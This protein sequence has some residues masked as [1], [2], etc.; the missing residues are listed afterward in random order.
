MHKK[1]AKIHKI[2]VDLDG[3][4]CN[5]DSS[6]LKSYRQIYPDYRF[7]PLD[8]RVGQCSD[9]DYLQ[10]FSR[11]E[12]NAVQRIL[13]T[14]GFFRTLEPNADAVEAVKRLNVRRRDLKVYLCTTPWYRN[15]TCVQDKMDW[16]EDNLGKR[17]IRKMIITPDKSLIKGDILFDDKPKVSG[18]FE[19]VM[20][21][22]QHNSH[23]DAKWVLEDWKD[24]EQIIDT[25]LHTS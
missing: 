20:V 17:W 19:H 7:I 15:S 22:C 3:V 18:E 5:L 24:V 11:K 9:L 2:L 10:R 25:V 23:V 4:L 13:K 21:R 1:F 8:Q 12:A 14:P 6:I 16:V